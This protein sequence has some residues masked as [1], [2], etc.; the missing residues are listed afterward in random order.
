LN[1]LFNIYNKYFVYKNETLLLLKLYK[2]NIKIE[3]I[4]KNLIEKGN[5]ITIFKINS[6]EQT[7]TFIVLRNNA[8]DNTKNHNILFINKKTLSDIELKKT[9][10]E[11]NDDKHKIIQQEKNFVPNTES[12]ITNT[13]SP[14]NNSDI[15]YQGTTYGFMLRGLFKK[16]KIKGIISIKTLEKLTKF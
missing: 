3:N 13:R 6:Q 15:Y 9:I 14:I 7:N 1:I 11:F 10:I 4:Q 8:T 5:N 12:I 16:L 2:N